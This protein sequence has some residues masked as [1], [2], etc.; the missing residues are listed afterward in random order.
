MQK[1]CSPTGLPIKLSRGPKPATLTGRTRRRSELLTPGS[2][3][4]SRC[5]EMICAIW[6]SSDTRWMSSSQTR[7]MLRQRNSQY[8]E[9]HSTQGSLMRTVDSN[10][11]ALV[12]VANDQEWAARSFET[13]LGAEGHRV[14]RAYTG[15]QALDRIETHRLDAIILDAQLP[16]LDGASVCQMMRRDPRVGPTIPIV[17][18]TAGPSGRQERLTA[19]R[20]GAWEFFGYPLDPETVLLKLRLFLDAKQA[21]D[22]IHERGLLDEVTGLYNRRG[23][24]RRGQELAA[25]AARRQDELSCILLKPNPRLVEVEPRVAKALA[26]RIGEILRETCRRSDV[27]GRFG[28]LDFAVLMVSALPVA[29]SIAARISEMAAKLGGPELVVEPCRWPEGLFGETA[30]AVEPVSQP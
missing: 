3:F 24:L 18:T 25:Q 19:H 10:P 29:E 20:A 7:F 28:P 5:C 26:P 27:V 2:L 8:Y 4:V 12:L 21:A 22:A 30:P 14:V 13:I 1:S 17:M 15:R 9:R 11:R 6:M 16:D 23:L